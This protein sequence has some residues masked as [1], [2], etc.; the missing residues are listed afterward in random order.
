MGVCREPRRLGAV[1]QRRRGDGA[2]RKRAN[3]TA[4][5]LAAVQSWGTEKVS[6]SQRSDALAVCPEKL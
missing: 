1:I 3:W 2:M 4:R 5:A 6:G